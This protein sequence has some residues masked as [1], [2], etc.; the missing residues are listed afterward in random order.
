[1]NDYLKYRKEMKTADIFEFASDSILG[2][3]IRM[4]TGYDVNHTSLLLKLNEFDSLKS[5]VFTLESLSSGI[6]L[7]LLSERVDKFKGS[8]YWYQLKSQ[9]DEH[10]SNIASWAL[11]QIDKKYDYWSIL[12]NLFGKVN[13]DSKLYFCSEYVHAAYKKEGLIN[14]IKACVPGD[15]GKYNLHYNRVKIK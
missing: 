5:R 4:K 10:R 12:A 13:I 14:D 9:H 7:H 6:E 15:F 11:E 3:L 8:I 1:M 2:K